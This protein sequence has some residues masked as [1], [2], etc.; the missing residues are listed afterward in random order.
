MVEITIGAALVAVGAGLAMGIAGAGSGLGQGQAAASSVGAVAEEPTMFAR[1]IVFTA[2]PET[3]AIYGFLIAL[4]LMV[5]SGLM[6]G[7]AVPTN[8]GILAIGAGLAIGVAAAGSGLGQG[9]AASASVGAVVEDPGMFAR[10]IVFSALPET[11][12]IYGFLIAL[13]LIVFSGIM[14]G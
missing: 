9:L 12:A 6:A 8:F 13:L 5:F 2:L 11:Q 7:K 3:Q 10:G 1:G 14:V 4:L